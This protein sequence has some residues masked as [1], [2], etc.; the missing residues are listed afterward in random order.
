MIEAVDPKNSSNIVGGIFSASNKYSLL[1]CPPHGSKSRLVKKFGDWN[2][3]LENIGRFPVYFGNK[4][5]K[6]F[7]TA[8]SDVSCNFFIF[9]EFFSFFK[10]SEH[11]L[12]YQIKSNL[13]QSFTFS[14]LSLTINL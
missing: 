14:F 10:N 12:S 4:N 8:S 2:E 6:I 13:I 7:I 9:S 3:S 5:S 11:L 1:T